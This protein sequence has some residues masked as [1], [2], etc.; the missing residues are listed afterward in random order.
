MFTK[1]IVDIDSFE[2]DGHADFMVELCYTNGDIAL[3]WI[4]NDSHVYSFEFY[5]KLLESMKNNVSYRESLGCIIYN[6]ATSK[7]ILDG[8]SGSCQFSVLKL[9]RDKG[10]KLVERILEARNNNP[11]Y[12]KWINNDK[13]CI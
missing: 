9:T 1:V 11:D 5:E 10:I 6:A 8:Y 13:K 2:D 7:L 3:S 4:I 12:I